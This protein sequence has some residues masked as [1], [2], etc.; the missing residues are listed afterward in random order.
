MRKEGGGSK[1]LRGEEKRRRRG[2]GEPEEVRGVM[3]QLKGV[4]CSRGERHNKRTS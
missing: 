4:K 1:H 3:E 2:E